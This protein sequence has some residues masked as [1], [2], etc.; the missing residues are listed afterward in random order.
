MSIAMGK[1]RCAQ[2]RSRDAAGATS[3][4]SR[5]ACTAR[6]LDDP[7]LTASTG[8]RKVIRSVFYGG[9]IRLSKRPKRTLTLKGAHID[10]IGVVVTTCAGCGKLD[11]LVNGKVIKTVSLRARST[12]NRVLVM[13]PRFAYRTATVILRTRS[14][15][16]VKVD[17]LVA[18]RI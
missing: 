6:A 9:S 18:T 11:V 5:P 2:V 10:R 1:T 14:K 8:W 7:S 13:L 15:S 4:W 12:H 3:A 17:G 16:P